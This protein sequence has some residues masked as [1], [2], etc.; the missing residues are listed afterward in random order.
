MLAGGYGKRLRPLTE[1]VPKPLLNILGKP[2]LCWQFEW[3]KIHGITEII[4]CVGHLKEKIMEEIGSGQKFGVKVGYVV[5]DEPLGTGGA[6]NNTMHLLNKEEAFIVINGDVL[7]NLNPVELVNALRDDV[8]GAIAVIP[9]PSPYGIVNF[10][11]TTFK[12]NEFREKPRIYDYWINAGIYA[13]TPKVFNYLPQQGDLEKTTFPE[14]A[15]RGLLKAV[16]FN[17]CEWMSIDTHKDLE[18]AA[19]LV[20]NLSFNH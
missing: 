20:K 7:T 18:E 9:L 3:L 8:I 17:E 12:I 4:M 14:L 15:S 19:K 10:N 16:P 11:G 2:I 13:F 1:S 6:L 5:E